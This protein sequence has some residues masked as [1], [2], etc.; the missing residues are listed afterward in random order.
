MSMSIP[1]TRRISG[2]KY[3]KNVQ[4]Y[5]TYIESDPKVILKQNI[6]NLYKT[7]RWHLVYI[8]PQKRLGITC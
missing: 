2:S 3:I 6:I 1:Y 5:I 7:L 8:H 4:L